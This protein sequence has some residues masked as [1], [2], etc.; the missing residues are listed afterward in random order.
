M[1]SGMNE[2][3]GAKVGTMITNIRANIIQGIEDKLPIQW[4]SR[5]HMRMMSEC[6]LGLNWDKMANGPTLFLL[7]ENGKPEQVK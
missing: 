6:D 3:V 7:D 2:I 4:L 5:A 1:I